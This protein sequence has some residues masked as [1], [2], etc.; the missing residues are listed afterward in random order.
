MRTE[1]QKIMKSF[2]EID[3][4]SKP[5]REMDS[6]LSRQIKSGKSPAESGGLYKDKRARCALRGKTTAFLMIRIVL[7]MVCALKVN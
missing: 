2:A 4:W 3:Q 5:R 7:V 6:F 1:G